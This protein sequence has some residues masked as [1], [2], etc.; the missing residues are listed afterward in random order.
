VIFTVDPTVR[1][2]H[3]ACL[4]AADIN[5]HLGR[6]TSSA[7]F[8]EAIKPIDKASEAILDLKPVTFRYKKELDRLVSHSLA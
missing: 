3:L 7:R 2:E 6:I 4:A 8:K 5:G 1:W